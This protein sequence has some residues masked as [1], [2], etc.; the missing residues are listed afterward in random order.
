MTVQSLN[1]FP[2]TPFV[3]FSRDL[4]LPR[5]AIY[6]ATAVVTAVLF[7]GGAAIYAYVTPPQAIEIPAVLPP[8][9]VPAPTPRSAEESALVAMSQAAPK[10]DKA[11]ANIIRIKSVLGADIFDAQNREIGE[12]VDVEFAKTGAAANAIIQLKEKE[13]VKKVRTIA[14]PMK[15][16][17]WAKR[18]DGDAFGIVQSADLPR[19]V[20]LGTA[21]Q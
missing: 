7:V 4:V 6:L 12:V 1:T 9:T 15:A 17:T 20:S 16:V 11:A 2:L 13:S 8:G 18:N 3:T 10:P 21:I 5:L 19:G 14:V